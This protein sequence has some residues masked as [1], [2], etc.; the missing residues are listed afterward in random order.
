MQR[1][2]EYLIRVSVLNKIKKYL[3][4]YNINYEKEIDKINCKVA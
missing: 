3:K 4:L 1:N 2:F